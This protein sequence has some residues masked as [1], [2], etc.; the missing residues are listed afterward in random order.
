VIRREA[1]A[2]VE[3]F[4]LS[5]FAV[6]QPLLDLFGRAPDQFI[7]RGAGTV[8]VLLFAG[9]IVLGLPLALWALGAGVRAA[10]PAAGRVVHV[11]SLAVLAWAF[12]VQVARPLVGGMPLQVL[13]AIVAVGVVVLLQRSRPARLWLGYAAIGPVA[14]LALFLVASD[15][16]RLVGSDEVPPVGAEIGAPVPVVLVVFDE[17]PLSSL[18]DADG[19]VDR[20]L[21]PNFAELAGTSHWFRNTTGV[22]S[23]TWNAVPSLVTGSMPEDRQV[24][25][26]RDHPQN[27][28]TLLAS[29]YELNVIESIT[30]LCPSNLCPSAGGAGR[31]VPALVGDAID[32][33]RARLSLSGD[34]GPATAGFDEPVDVL[35]DPDAGSA[36]LAIGPQRV[37]EFIG[38]IEGDGLALHYL[39]VLL[40]HHPFRFLPSGRQYV[41]PPS[42]PGRFGDEWDDQRRP[43]EL[44]RQ[45]HLLQLAYVDDQLGRMMASMRE[46]D[47]WDGA[48]VIVTADHGISFRPGGPVRLAS[49]QPITDEVAPELMWVP[50]FVKLPGQVAGEVSDANVQIVD[51]LP[52]IADVLD[53]DLPEP[54]DGRSVF[55]PPRSSADK[56]FYGGGFVSDGVVV[57]DEVVIDGD[58]GF[59]T[60][61]ELATGTF[62]PPPGGRERLWSIG[63]ADTLVGA[64]AD[65]LPVVEAALAVPAPELDPESGMVPSYVAAVLFDIQVGDPVAIAVNGV[66]AATGEVWEDAGREVVAVMVDEERFREGPNEV[67]VHRIEAP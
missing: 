9:V 33:L 21:F 48:L 27:L 18:L 3:L 64:P 54:V 61:L 10:R 59:A 62:V 2:F 14:F 39:H 15:S 63:P 7:F 25:F 17:L 8:D 60:A 51:V 43:T 19:G 5:G 30:Q 13:A 52:T 12:L 58:E 26:A 42:D 66:V 4:A 32:V 16:A 65:D 45:R 57:A 11:V 20:R 53:I 46:A 31:A 24:P 47:L 55:G 34:A 29:G 44:A 41:Y 36:E 49:G 28:F 56:A 50:L 35:R 67:T 40:P 22:S 23:F 37:N 6:A 1:R 38:G